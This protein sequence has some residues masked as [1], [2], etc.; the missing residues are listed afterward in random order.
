MKRRL[1]KPALVFC[2]ISEGVPLS[3][4][5]AGVA[6][7]PATRQRAVPALELGGVLLGCGS[8][9]SAELDHPFIFLNEHAR[10]FHEVKEMAF[11]N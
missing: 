5:V 10:L 8:W 11:A 3:F 1:R 4:A 2:Q 9:A 7:R 6:C